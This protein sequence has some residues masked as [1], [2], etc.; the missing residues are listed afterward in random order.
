MGGQLGANSTKGKKEAKKEP[1][2]T[3]ETGHIPDRNEMKLKRS[4]RNVTENTDLS[5]ANISK[6]FP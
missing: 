3:K 6:K 4:I 1:E 5:T 2:G